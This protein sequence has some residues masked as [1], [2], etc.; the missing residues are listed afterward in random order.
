MAGLHALIFDVDGTL[1]ETEEIHR[2]AFNAA[3][4]ARGLDWHWDPPLYKVLLSVTGGKERI[5]FYIDR[6]QPRGG[7]ALDEPAVA[8][9]HADKTR[10]YGEMVAAGDVCLRPG[11][12]ALMCEAKAADLR[13][14]IATTTSLGNVAALLNA[15]LGDEAMGW[16]DVIGA[17]EHAERKKP[18]PDIYRWV[19]AKLQC[20]P[21]Q[22]LAIEDSENGLRAARG[23]GITTLITPSRYTE[24][25]DFSG[26]ARVVPNLADVTLGELE[27]LL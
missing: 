8:Q 5:R 19:L 27:A 9:L 4:E 25:D 17:G 13:L 21:S 3:F 22:A 26:A 16:F 7:E 1:A 11:V 10:R 15:T 14:A 2:L 23:A 24:D 18:A 20:D 6:Y 12:E